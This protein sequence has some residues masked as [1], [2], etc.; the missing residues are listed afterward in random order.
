MLQSSIWKL[1]PEHSGVDGVVEDAGLSH[2]RLRMR[3]PPLQAREQEF[4]DPHGDH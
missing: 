1:Q 3:I 4:H 2:V